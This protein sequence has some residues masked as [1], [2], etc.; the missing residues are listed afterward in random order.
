MPQACP[1]L[2]WRSTAARWLARGAIKRAFK[3]ARDRAVRVAWREERRLVRETGQGTRRWTQAEKRE[4]LGEGKVKGYDGHHRNTVK[5]NDIESAGNPDNIEFLTEAEHTRLHIDA[6][7]YQV[8]ISG[9]PNLD[10]TAGGSVAQ[11]PRDSPPAGPLATIA[12]VAPVVEELL[13]LTSLNPLDAG[14]AN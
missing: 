11:A 13:N 7:G 4:L 6:G 8:P 14:E 10:R 3:V 5:E 9:R 1:S 12:A 2:D